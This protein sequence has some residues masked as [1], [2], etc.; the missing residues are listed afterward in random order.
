MRSRRGVIR[1]AGSDDEADNPP[2]SASSGI[3]HSD[4]PFGFLCPPGRS[5]GG[6]EVVGR[7]LGTA[8]FLALMF[9]VI[10]RRMIPCHVFFLRHRPVVARPFAQ[11]RIRC[12]RRDFAIE[13]SPAFEFVKR[14]LRGGE[15]FIR[16]VGREFRAARTLQF[17]VRAGMEPQR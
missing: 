12:P 6:V 13:P 8:A 16:C 1:S 11:V 3:V 14:F 10:V 7:N 15:R 4:L 2:G 17:E 5:L 9:G